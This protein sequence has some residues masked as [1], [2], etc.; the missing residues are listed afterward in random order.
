MLF[1][2]VMVASAFVSPVNSPPA[3]LVGPPAPPAV[4]SPLLASRALLVPTAALPEDPV[5]AS[6]EV[7]P[8]IQGAGIA[9]AGLVEAN[10]R[11]TL[12]SAKFI[13]PLAIDGNV[14]VKIHTWDQLHL[15]ARVGAFFAR[16]DLVDPGQMAP[17]AGVTGTYCFDLACGGSVSLGGMVSRVQ[18]S[19]DSGPRTFTSGGPELALLLTPLRRERW[20]LQVAAEVQRLPI[21]EN[22]SDNW[23]AGLGVRVAGR[24][25]HGELGLIGFTR[26]HSSKSDLVPLPWA[27]VGFRL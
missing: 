8:F 1:L 16:H 17:Y 14:K 7:G 15:A 10:L 25:V 3:T 18:S 20:V 23:L 26:S 11:M 21:G 24:H 5:V 2:A 27:Q 22:L 6:L 13:D 4:R 9:L 12:L 19:P